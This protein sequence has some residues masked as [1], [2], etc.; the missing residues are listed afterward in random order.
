MTHD[1]Q[2]WAGTAVQWNGADIA[3][4]RDKLPIG[5]DVPHW[6]VVDGLVYAV[7]GGRWLAPANA[8]PLR[9]WRKL[10]RLTR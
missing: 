5:R 7:E 10:D 1:G 2:P 9:E 8:V 3:I 6:L 4:S